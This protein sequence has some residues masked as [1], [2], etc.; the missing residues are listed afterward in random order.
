MLEALVVGECAVLG[1]GA[2]VVAFG[3]AAD[4]P[5]AEAPHPATMEIAMIT[6]AAPT[7]FVFARHVMAAP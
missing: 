6:A 2:D 1:L 7:K 3:S 4:G 5:G